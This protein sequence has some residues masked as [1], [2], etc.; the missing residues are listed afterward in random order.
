MSIIILTNKT[1]NNL[2]DYEDL[3]IINKPIKLLDEFHLEYDNK[4]IE[5]DYLLAED[6]SYLTNYQDLPFI[7]DNGVILTNWVGQTTIENIYVGNLDKA[8]DELFNN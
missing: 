5:F 8:L 7:I 2:P 4:I 3:I 1:I 6:Q